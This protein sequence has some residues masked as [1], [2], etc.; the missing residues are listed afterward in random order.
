MTHR[1]PH[2]RRTFAEV[3]RHRSLLFLGAGL[4][5][6][7]LLELFGE[8]LEMEGANPTLHYALMPEGRVDPDFLLARFNILV[9]EHPEG[10]YKDVEDALTAL[11]ETLKKPRAKTIRWVHSLACKSRLGVGGDSDTL[12]IVRGPLVSPGPKECMAISIGR[13][14]NTAHVSDSVKGVLQQ[15]GVHLDDSGM[16]DPKGY[17]WL[18]DYIAQF[19]GNKRSPHAAAS[20]SR[21]L[22]LQREIQGVGVPPRIGEM[23][24]L[25]GQRSGR[26]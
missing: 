7:Y 10:R 11:K 21:S 25:S 15:A 17:R 24:G 12:Q 2:F 8:V 1:I 14:R 9:A 16:V 22:A 26:S 13:E 5:D 4:E 18:G 23:S 20:G 3:Y 6:R 19:S